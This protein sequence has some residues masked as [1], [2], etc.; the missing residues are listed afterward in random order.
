MT[1]TAAERELDGKRVS[2]PAGLLVAN[3]SRGRTQLRSLLTRFNGSF[4]ADHNGALPSTPLLFPG[5]I[6]EV[7]VFVFCLFVLDLDL[8]SRLWNRHYFK[9]S[10]KSRARFVQ[11]DS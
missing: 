11:S 5:P 7:G 9:S 10:Y 6:V 4:P 2:Q 3:C 8:E 1:V